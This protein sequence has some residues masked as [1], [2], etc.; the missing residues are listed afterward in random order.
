MES[1]ILG[2]DDTLEVPSLLFKIMVEQGEA[3]A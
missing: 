2:V 1:D 3:Q